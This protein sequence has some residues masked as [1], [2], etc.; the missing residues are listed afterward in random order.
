V[1]VEARRRL[2]KSPP[3]LWAELSDEQSLARRLAEFGEIR[4]SRIEPESTVAWEGER[5]RGTVEIETSGWGTAVLIT[6]VPVEDSRAETPVPG[7]PGTPPTPAPGPPTPAPD[8]MPQ[9]PTPDPEPPTPGPEPG[10]PGPP[11]P[12]PQISGGEARSSSFFARLFRRRAET[13]EIPPDPSP[14]PVP[15][16]G[17][18]VPEPPPDPAP[19][20]DPDPLPPP[21][22]L[23]AHPDPPLPA[24]GLPSPPDAKAP[25]P[26][27]RE[28][29]QEILEAVLD[30]LGAAHHRPFSRA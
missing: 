23:P 11:S 18:P 6:A 25:E 15:P 10:P 20:P 28:R 22:P 4:I 17:E 13:A 5:G 9:P 2:V 21:E 19:L 12:G 1:E 29:A 30:D 27:S 7:P 14:E 26:L 3:E 8:P 24:A 16:P